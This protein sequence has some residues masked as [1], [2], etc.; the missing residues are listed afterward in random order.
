MMLQAE[1]LFLYTPWIS[2]HAPNSSKGIALT[3]FSR[4]KIVNKGPAQQ[5]EVTDALIPEF[6][7]RGY[8]LHVLRECKQR[9]FGGSHSECDRSPNAILVPFEMQYSKSAERIGMS[10]AIIEHPSALGVTV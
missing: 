8:P 5:L 9:V 2:N 3:G 6:I 4:M 7:A 1:A 10:S